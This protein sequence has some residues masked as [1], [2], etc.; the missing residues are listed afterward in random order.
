MKKYSGLLSPEV[1]WL[2]LR[3]FLGFLFL[4]SGMEKL[5]NF[6]G[7]VLTGILTSWIN[8]V[9]SVPPNPNLW[10]VGFL[11][12]VVIPQA[13]LFATLV[14]YGEILVGI[15]L[16]LGLFTSIV[17]LIGAFLNA[18]YYFAAAQTSASTQI[19]NALFI[20]V[21]LLFALACVGQYYGLD[22][23]LLPI[24]WGPRSNELKKTVSS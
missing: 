10:Y 21:Q 7:K 11:K 20:V 24:L 23:Y 22:H 16:I 9:G 1:A 2:L 8:G 6:S 12:G 4:Y 14:S 18:N 5:G 15:A 19:V 3:I 17:A 13:G